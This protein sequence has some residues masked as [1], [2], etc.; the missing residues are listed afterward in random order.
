MTIIASS[1]LTSKGQVTIPNRIRKI[2]HLGQGS[3]VVF[4]LG[5]E[6]IVISPA[7]IIVDAPYS[8]YE[9]KKIEKIVAEKGRVYKTVKRAKG[10]IEKL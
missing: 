7:E 10:H 3:T 1:K 8:A 9:W 6:G 2:L 5:K 4:G